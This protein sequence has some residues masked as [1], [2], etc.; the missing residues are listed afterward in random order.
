M[1]R[2]TVP[3]RARSACRPVGVEL[4]GRLTRGQT[5]VDWRT[6]EVR[7]Q[8]GVGVGG[9]SEAGRK[10]VEVVQEAD[11]ERFEGMLKRAL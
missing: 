6:R 3:R 1:P 5:L 10:N 11:L 2:R 9:E 7:R 8:W 4:E